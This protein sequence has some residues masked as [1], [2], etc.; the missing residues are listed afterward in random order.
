ML[1]FFMFRIYEAE[2]IELNPEVSLVLL[3]PPVDS[4]CSAPG[5]KDDVTE[6]TD[7]VL[8]PLQVFEMSMWL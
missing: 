8:L 7:C 6:R 1:F 2:V 5:Q 3:L 4:V